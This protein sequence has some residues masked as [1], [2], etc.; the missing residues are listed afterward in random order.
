MIDA[1][2]VQEGFEA[3]A[4]THGSIDLTLARA[5]SGQL[6]PKTSD[7]TLCFATYYKRETEL[8]WRAWANRNP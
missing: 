3:W 5:K 8:A 1:Q 7:G 4:R 2:A 6:V